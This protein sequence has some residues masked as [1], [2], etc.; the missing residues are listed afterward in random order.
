MPDAMRPNEGT[1]LEAAPEAT[2]LHAID[3]LTGSSHLTALGSIE[4][5]LIELGSIGIVSCPVRI[6]DYFSTVCR[7]RPDNSFLWFPIVR[8]A[9]HI[10]DLGSGQLH[11]IAYLNSVTYDVC[12][13]INSVANSR[14]ATELPPQVTVAN[15]DVASNENGD[16]VAGTNG[17]A[18]TLTAAS[19]AVIDAANAAW[20]EGC[21]YVGATAPNTAAIQAAGPFIY[22]RV[23]YQN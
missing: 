2:S 1:M 17:G 22:F 3:F 20:N 19:G 11:T 15:F 5:H 23:V 8:S 14:P 10:A 4:S 21:V 7:A 6:L 12:R 13:Q 18:I 9:Q 16:G